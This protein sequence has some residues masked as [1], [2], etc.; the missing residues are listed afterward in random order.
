[1]VVSLTTACE[2][3]VKGGK[4]WGSVEGGKSR[5][6]YDAKAKDINHIAKSDVG[7]D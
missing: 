2:S 5:G 4:G 3:E 7:I 6:A 1:M